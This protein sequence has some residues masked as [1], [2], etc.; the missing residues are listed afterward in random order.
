MKKY[1]LVCFYLIVHFQILGQCNFTINYSKSDYQCSGGGSIGGIPLPLY[2]SITANLTNGIPPFQYKLNNSNFQ[3]S[4]SF[5]NLNAGIYTLVVKDSTN[6]LDST[7]ITINQPP[8]PVISN[9]NTT[10]ASCIPGCD[11]TLSIQATSGTLPYQYA[12]SY[13]QFGPQLQTSNQFSGLC[14][15]AYTIMVLD[16]NGCSNSQ[17][18]SINTYPNPSFSISNTILPSCNP[19]CDG[20][21]TVAGSPNAFYTIYPLGNLGAMGT[22][23]GLCNGFTYTITATDV[24]G[25]TNT[26]TLQLFSTSPGPSITVSSISDATCPFSCDGSAQINGTSSLL[27]S[28]IGQGSPT[29]SASGL[30]SNLCAGNYQ[31]V[32]YDSNNCTTSTIINV[33]ANTP[34]TS[35]NITK[36]QNESCSPGNDGYV[37]V[38]GYGSNPNLIYDIQPFSPSLSISNDTIKGLSA[39]IYTITATDPST[40]CYTSITA[41]LF[42]GSNPNVIVNTKTPPF[43]NLACSGSVTLYTSALSNIAIFPS[44]NIVSNTSITNLCA[45]TLYTVVA[46][47]AANCTSST[48]FWIFDQNLNL[49]LSSITK[50]T[51]NPGGDGAFTVTSNGQVPITYSIVG[52]QMQQSNT[53]GIFTGLS[54]YIYTITVTDANG[55]TKTSIYN[56]L[57]NVPSVII[58]SSSAPS[59]IPGCDGV[60]TFNTTPGLSYTIT[61]G[62]FINPQSGQLSSLCAYTNYIVTATDAGGCLATTTLQLVN[63]PTQPIY[64]TQIT[65]P[66]CTPGCDG[67]ASI[68]NPIFGGNYN[69]SPGGT[70]NPANGLISNL[71]TGITYQIT[72]VDANGC[73]R[74]TSLQLYQ[75]NT[76]NLSI[77]SV[78]IPSCSPGCDAQA[79][80][81]ST[82]GTGSKV[83]SISPAANINPTTGVV[84]SLCANSI[85]TITVTDASGCTA[86]VVLYTPSNPNP[87]LNQHVITATS[88]QQACNGAITFTISNQTPS[89]KIYRYATAT[90]TDKLDSTLASNPTFQNLCEGY[91]YFQT[92]DSICTWNRLVYYIPYNPQSIPEATVIYPCKNQ[93]NGSIRV[94]NLLPNTTYSLNP[95]P[96]GVQQI[97]PG[98]FINLPHSNYTISA[99]DTITTCQN[100]KSFF[101]NQPSPNAY[102]LTSTCDSNSFC[103][104]KLNMYQSRINRPFVYSFF[105]NTNINKINDSVYIGFCKDST[106]QVT[107]TD[108]IGCI[109]S[110]NEFINNAPLSI[111]VQTVNPPC[112]ICNG[113]ISV[114]QNIVN[115]FQNFELKDSFS[116]QSNQTGIFNGL[117]QGIYTITSSDTFG[118]C[119]ERIVVLSPI[120]TQLNITHNPCKDFCQG[121]ITINP[122]GSTGP[123]STSIFPNIGIANGNTISELCAGTYTL[124]I[125]DAIGCSKDTTFI[126]T[127][128]SKIEGTIS[129]IFPSVCGLAN[130]QITLGR[131]G[132]SGDA[133]YEINPGNFKGPITSS[134]GTLVSNLPSNTYTCVISDAKQ[135][136]DSIQFVVT[137]TIPN[138]IDTIKTVPTSCHKADGLIWITL[139]S[140][141]PYKLDSIALDNL[142]WTRNYYFEYIDY[143][144]HTI[145]I[146]TIDGCIDSATTYVG[147][148]NNLQVVDLNLETE[149]CAGT[150]DGKIILPVNDF[151]YSIEPYHPV[152]YQN[153]VIENLPVGHYTLTA[154]D[155]RGCSGAT[156]VSIAKA[157][158]LELSTQLLYSTYGDC[159][160]EVQITAQGGTPPYSFQVEPANFATI[161]DSGLLNYLCNTNYTISVIDKHGCQQMQQVFIP[162]QDLD[163]DDFTIYPNPSQKEINFLFSRT[164]D[165]VISI[166]DIS[167]RVIDHDIY[168]E[169]TK[170]SIPVSHYSDGIYFVTL[171]FD[172]Q[173]FIRKIQVQH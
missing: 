156:V 20:Q 149:R 100:S 109:Y 168:L 114:N 19:G 89:M 170:I 51:C 9:I 49:S 31:F 158:P 47:D 134:F 41:F 88:C 35:L 169:R 1:L 132:G 160:G 135:C 126:I 108:S 8:Q 121:T 146:K 113:S 59:C 153:R 17:V 15:V 96:A 116:V 83:Y 94:T 84:S 93:S 115:P 75:F 123:Y 78:T 21:I 151:T 65:P 32:A 163:G 70:I 58:T 161:S 54:S 164:I 79:F 107:L 97:S 82:G 130:G 81:T 45:N 87:I 25:C 131:S 137:D 64:L 62:G 120:K 98:Y 7:V 144:T 171:N 159:H 48:M 101:L 142:G 36:T 50:P 14:T 60:A 4:N 110:F 117:C 127:E 27:Y 23:Y 67:S 16:S 136:K 173:K 128:P 28:T 71:C 165:V 162:Y 141:L 155:A 118:F 30:I 34:V 12:I 103:N 74:T 33:G 44:G 2:G 119:A 63:P 46:T 77:S 5:D 53:T 73:T 72:V 24:N 157:S 39:N 42:V 37:V 3:S 106:Y 22:F 52:N 29:I 38:P 86:T 122:S 10:L 112:N 26:N 138:F 6:C 85:F 143:G 55:C 66:T 167:G 40:A 145:Y 140:G 92:V 124:H 69:V 104:N 150:D 172:G 111:Y 11:G 166:S 80:V 129:N 148:K 125:V 152:N 154:T 61:P 95:M 13:S 99:T 90:S 57:P 139:K 105:P 68:W 91:Y 76:L 43:C 147:F 102:S 133:N 56:L 18:H